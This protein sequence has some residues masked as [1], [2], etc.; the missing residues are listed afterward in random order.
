[1]AKVGILT[2]G[3]GLGRSYEFEIF[4]WGTSF[5]PVTAVYTVTRRVAAKDGSYSHVVVYIGETGD[6]S[7]RFDNHHKADAMARHN[8]NCINVLQEGN[9]EA[10]LR[11]EAD[12]I[13]KFNPPC[14]G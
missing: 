6:L 13:A 7:T 3:G 14:N 1:M 9:A 4:P 11:T 10:R 2:L 8:A 12:L 5:N